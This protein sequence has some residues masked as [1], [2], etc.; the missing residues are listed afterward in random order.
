[1]KKTKDDIIEEVYN[2]KS[3]FG[4]VQ[5]TYKQIK[6]FDE[7]R[8]KNSGITIK[9]VK[10][11]FFNN[12]ENIAKLKGYN[13]YINN[14]AYEEY[15]M[16]HIFF[17]R[18]PENNLALTM[19]DTFSKFAVVVRMKGKTKENVLAAVM[20]GITKMREK[21]KMLYCDRDKTFT[22]KLLA[23]YCN[24]ENIKLIFTHTHPPVVE[25]FN[26]T[27]KSMIWKRLKAD[28]TKKKSGRIS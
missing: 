6:A 25:R 15:Q 17:G 23:E 22:G 7:R 4:T 13:S 3:E 5:K 8:G 26:R 11:W 16:D 20:E 9:D 12:V 10:E 1:M 28:K 2:D 27:F 14:A 21:P 18:D 19:I 24:K